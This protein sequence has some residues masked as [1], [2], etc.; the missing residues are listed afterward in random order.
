MLSIFAL[1]VA[2]TQAAQFFETP[3]DSVTNADGSCFLRAYNRDV[4]KPVTS[5]D[6]WGD[7]YPEDDASL[8]Y[9]YC[10]EGYEGFSNLC[11]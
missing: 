5:C 8:C 7:E 3:S 11:W 6:Y 9:A 1:C 4:G 10:D 2:V